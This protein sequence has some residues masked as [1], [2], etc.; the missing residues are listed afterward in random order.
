M[1]RPDHPDRAAS[2]RHTE[3]RGDSL[4]NDRRDFMK[5]TALTGLGTALGGMSLSSCSS[6][7]TGTTGKQ[8]PAPEELFAAAPI[9]EVRIG[10]VGVGGMGSAHIN[11]LVKIPGC[12]ITALCD[13]VPGRAE[14]NAD[15]VEKAGFPRPKLFTA[16]ETDW[17]NLCASDDVDL[18]YT[19][20]PWRWHV[21]I[22]LAAMENGKHAA[23]EVPMALTIDECWQLVDTAERTQ[24][25]CVMMENCC[26]GRSEMMV[27]NM[28]RQGVLGEIVHAE[29]G[30]MHDLRGVK[31]DMDGEGVWRRKHSMERDANLYPT[32]G[33]GP[34]AQVMNINRGDAFDYLVSMSSTSRGLQDY[35]L[36]HFP[37]D[38]PVR[39]ETYELGDVNFCM[40]KTRLGHTITVGHDC[41]LPRPYSRINIV[42]GTRGIVQGY[43]DRIYIEGVSEPHQWDKL[44]DHADKFEHPLYTRLAA[45]AKGAGHGGMDFF[46]DVRLIESLNHGEAMDMDVYDGAALSVITHCT[47]ISN[48]DRSR[49]VD[50]P[51]F[52]RGRWRSRPPLEARA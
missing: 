41:N 51:D 37:E 13:V 30:Y 6:T 27:L 29:A 4:S 46:E 48:G 31:H 3:P 45:A 32:H 39:S 7:G 33:L 16:G 17:K 10:F 19:A 34:V 22:C 47:E 14:S 12:R 50:I 24:R 25:H 43:P 44:M 20:T 28:A 49:P 36:E 11:N 1:T 52:T 9:E 18:V 38:H 42:Q 15:K 5:F 40:I 23:T 26:Y 8:E 35:A 21:P 2:L